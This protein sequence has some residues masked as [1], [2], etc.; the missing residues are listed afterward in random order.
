MLNFD[1]TFKKKVMTS[2]FIKWKKEYNTGISIID[3]QH[4]RLVEMI[5]ELY[6]SFMKKEHKDKVKDIIKEMSAYTYKHFKT[7]ER[8]FDMYGYSGKE[9]HVQEHQKF[10]KKVCEFQEMLVENK[11]SLTFK[12][13]SF[14]Q[15]WL[16]RHIG[17]SDQKYV[18]ELK[19]AGLT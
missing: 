12:V 6:D 5:N 19:R 7:E 4:Q 10:M 11:T 9:D 15:E 17:E 3:E 2:Q 8:F 18:V 13:L 14:L 1:L 16:L